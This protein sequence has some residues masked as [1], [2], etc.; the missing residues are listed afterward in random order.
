MGMPLTGCY[1]SQL[2]ELG[3]NTECR[4]MCACTDNK[5]NYMVPV[6][7]FENIKWLFKHVG[8][9]ESSKDTCQI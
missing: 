1:D 5:P 9:V 4:V 8:Y 2:A 3:S 6:S 7:T